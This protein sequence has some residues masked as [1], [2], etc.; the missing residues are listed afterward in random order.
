M[1]SGKECDPFSAGLP[2]RFRISGCKPAPECENVEEPRSE[3]GG[4]MNNRILAVVLVG[5]VTLLSTPAGAARAPLTVA[6]YFTNSMVLQQGRPVPVWGTATA[7]S[8]ITLSLS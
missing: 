8:T 7:G 4:K 2:V 1:M 3:D 5:V 6:P